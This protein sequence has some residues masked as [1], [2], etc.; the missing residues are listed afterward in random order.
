MIHTATPFV[1]GRRAIRDRVTEWLPPCDH[2][3]IDDG[4][5]GE[6]VKTVYRHAGKRVD[7]FHE[8]LPAIR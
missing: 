1:L 2:D 5:I 3:G 6:Q 8:P 4:L 7:M